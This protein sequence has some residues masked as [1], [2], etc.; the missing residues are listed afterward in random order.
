MRLL[1]TGGCGFIGCNL[2]RHI[3]D[4]PGIELLVNLD[5]LTYAGS[6]NNVRDVADRPQYRFEKVDLRDKLA[7]VDV[8]LRHRVTHVIHLAAES[9]VDR[10][11]YSPGDF[12]H[13]N[14][15]GTYH[16]IEACREAWQSTRIETTQQGAHGDAAQAAGACRFLHVSTDEVYGSLGESDRSSELSAY[17]PNSPYAASKASS[18]FL[19]RAYHHTYGFPAIITNSSNNF[20]P[21]Q[22][23]EKLIP[24]VITKLIHRQPIPIYGDG[25][26]VRDWIYVQDHAEALWAVLA[27][28][29]PGESYNIGALNEWS[30]L[31][32]VELMC[33]LFDELEPAAGGN[34][35]RLMSFVTDRPGHDRRYALDTTKIRTQI[36]WQPKADF[37]SSLRSTIEWYL[38][39]AVNH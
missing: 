21:H 25:L 12:I 36:G 11:I 17:A 26:N 9:H 28:G 37:E 4:Q 19:V 14:I 32:L 35:R 5:C 38:R 7:V 34:S 3:I 24:V 15:V 33:D 18:D 39:S 20:G 16:L 30:N 22:Y 8:L 13:T 31:R 1:V 29:V 10:S 27:R 6:M 2:I 23:P